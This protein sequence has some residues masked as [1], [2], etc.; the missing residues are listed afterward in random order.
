MEGNNRVAWREGMFLRPQHFQAQDRFVDAQ[1]RARADCLRP[2]PWGFTQLTIDED[3]AGFGKF[4][5]IRAS[6]V[7]PD[8]TPFSIPAD[9]PPPEPIEVPEDTRDAVIYLTLPTRQDGVVEFRE[10]EG[11][12]VDARY[13][14]GETDVI[15]TFSNDRVAE[16]IEL[17][18]L[19]LRFG[20]THEQLEGR[21]RLGVARIREIHRKRLMFD[22]RFIPPALDVEASSRLRGATTDIL[23]RADQRARELSVNAVEAT[24]GGADTFQNFLLLQALNRWTPVLQHLANLPMVHPERLFEALVSMGGEIATLIRQ[25]RKPPPLPLYDHENPQSCFDPV[26]DLLQSLLAAVFERAAVRL[27]LESKGSGAYAVVIRDHS[28]FQSGLFYLAVSSALPLEEVRRL[29][30]S[31][32]KI[33]PTTRMREIVDSALPG[34]PLRHVPTAPPQIRAM[35]GYVYFEL[36]RSVPGWSDFASAPGLG[37]LVAGDWPG[38]ALELWCVKR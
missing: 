1:L 33:G 12:A 4:G 23:G 20:V 5:L 15:D 35:Q 34:I 31:V 9:I 22:D 13:V 18:R 14:V 29:F 21:I 11:R 19:N 3:L 24:D 32:A 8:G 36:D 26:I 27:P 6:G 7:L 38:L 28:L 17:G 25:D 16:P 37:M 2:W 30:P 10:E